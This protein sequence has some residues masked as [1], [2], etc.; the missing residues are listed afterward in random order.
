MPTAAAVAVAVVQALLTSSVK[1]RET[2]P[3]ATLLPPKRRR[4]L[5][6]FWASSLKTKNV[7]LRW[8]SATAV[9]ILLTLLNTTATPPV[10]VAP[11]FWAVTRCANLP[12]LAVATA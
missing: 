2:S 4:R 10:Q 8:L 1:A 5:L 11:P 12:A 7:R 3:P 9:L 6:K